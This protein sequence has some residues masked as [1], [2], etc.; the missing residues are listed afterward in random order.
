MTSWLALVI[1]ATFAGFLSG[2]AL[3]DDA[4]HES[5]RSEIASRRE[6]L[7]SLPFKEGYPTK[8][9]ASILSDELLFQR[10]TQVYLWALPAVNLYAMKEGSEGA[11]GAGYTVFPVWKRRLDTKTVI[12]T[13]NSDVI[14]ALGYI[15][16]GK[17]GPM[18][19]EVPA[20]QQGI[21]NDFWQRPIEGP[22]IDGTTYAGDVGFAGPDRGNGGKFLVLPPGY[23]G[24]IP[25]GYFVYR[26]RTNN[27]LIFWRAFFADPARLA[28]P[29]S[30]MEQTHI[31]PLG[32]PAETMRFPDASAV[33]VNMNYPADGRF[34]DMLARFIDS[35]PRDTAD[36][37]WR[38]MMAA[39][40]IVK[41][42]PFKPDGHT[43][44]ILDQAARTAFRMSRSM[45]Y[46][47]LAQRPGGLIYP[48]RH[49]V[50]PTRNFVTDWEWMDKT[51]GFL[52]LDARSAAYSVIFGTSPAMGSAVP[53]QGARY[54]TTFKD[55]DAAFL[56]GE[57]NYRLHLP[58]NVPAA[59]F[60]SVT[61]YDSQTASGL[62]NGEPFPSIGSRDK[63]LANAD[64]STDLYFGP[65]APAGKKRNWRRT[66]PGQGFFVM[67][68]LYGPTQAYFDQNWKPGDLERVQ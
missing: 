34:F 4:A 43:R 54:L 64:G 61:L 49:Y 46:E 50:T 58:P 7:A 37:E 41:G 38:G 48:D 27:V 67:L 24:K 14:Y 40:G 20:K 22:T 11:F 17:N 25:D 36:P 33:P 30:L 28:L 59:V 9:E 23:Q 2:C 65:Q 68:R 3:R 26:S 63:P 15:D 13:P 16:V 6:S 39:I 55:A 21:L 60:W 35:E 8:D 19:I 1:F 29:V 62:D 57:R 56:R 66:V 12:P 42:Q 53:G 45:M 10:A 31:Y 51:A 32:R 44:Q 47:G 5:S 18:V 52:D